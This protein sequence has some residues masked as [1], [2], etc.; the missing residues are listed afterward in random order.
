MFFELYCK[1]RKAFSHITKLVL[2]SFNDVFCLF[3]LK[4]ELS[5]LLIDN[6]NVVA[7]LLNLMIQ[8]LIGF[9]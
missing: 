7:K 2:L 3:V 9:F 8:Q 4:S 6:T 1:C 5:I